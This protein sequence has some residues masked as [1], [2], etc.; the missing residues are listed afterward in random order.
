MEWLTDIREGVDDIN[1]MARHNFNVIGCF[2]MACLALLQF[3]FSW[4]MHVDMPHEKDESLTIPELSNASDRMHVEDQGNM[5]SESTLI[6]L[7]KNGGNRNVEDARIN[8]P[9]KNETRSI[10]RIPIRNENSTADTDGKERLTFHFIY[11]GR[12]YNFQPFMLRAVESV[13]YHHPDAQVR[14]HHSQIGRFELPYLKPLFKDFDL[15][16]EHYKLE[17]K[18]ESMKTQFK[19]TELL[20]SFIDN[21]SNWTETSKFRE[22]N[23]CNV[24]RLVLLYT[25]GGIY[26][27][28]DSILVR[29]MHT[30]G[31]NVIGKQSEKSINGAVLKFQKGNIFLEKALENMFNEFVPYKWGYQGP[32]LMTRTLSKDF[33]Q[34]KWREPVSREGVKNATAC[35]VD[36]MGVDAFYPLH[37]AETDKICYDSSINDTIVQEWKR[38]LDT[39]TYAA[40]I[41][42]KKK[43]M[44]TKP[45]TLCRWI[46]NAFCVTNETCEMVV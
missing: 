23:K 16:M 41:T 44:V 21:L 46:K 20:Q 7:M 11:N 45:G 22:Y 5:T 31:N 8:L 27:D 14:I 18:L 13:F 19:E 40:H 29:Q 2:I 3:S 9:K 26:M 12:R 32:K 15:A 42:G 39:N 37:F 6:S 34:C 24:Y 17:E 28:L 10:A 25:R 30:L 36:V 33:R 43:H 38:V 1:K 35:P 4:K